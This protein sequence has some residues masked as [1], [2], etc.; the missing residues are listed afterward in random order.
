VDRGYGFLLPLGDPVC[1]NRKNQV[2]PAEAAA[3]VAI[4]LWHYQDFY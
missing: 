3:V 1:H 2:T 4:A